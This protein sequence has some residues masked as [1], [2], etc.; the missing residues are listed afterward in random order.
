MAQI[1]VLLRLLYDFGFCAFLGG[2]M[3]PAVTGADTVDAALAS[4]RRD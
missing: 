2:A 4:E 1:C 3:I